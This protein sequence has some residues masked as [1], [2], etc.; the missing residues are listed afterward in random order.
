MSARLKPGLPEQ[1]HSLVWAIV[2]FGERWVVLITGVLLLAV[3]MAGAAAVAA[4]ARVSNH[5]L[6]AFC[7]YAVIFTMIPMVPYL[8]WIAQRRKLER[9]KRDANPDGGDDGSFTRPEA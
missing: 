6:G 8:G 4:T 9:L 3:S 2:E 1:H 5:W 7:L